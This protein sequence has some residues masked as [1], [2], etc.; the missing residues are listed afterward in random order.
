MVVAGIAFSK[1]ESSAYIT[2]KGSKT[3]IVGRVLMYHSEWSGVGA[4]SAVFIMWIGKRRCIKFVI[5]YSL[6]INN[7]S[8][9]DLRGFT[10]SDYFWSTYP[11]GTKEMSVGKTVQDFYQ[12]CRGVCSF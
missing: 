9:V 1:K 2:C 10:Q 11:Y 7:S 3:N 12:S 5:L 8:I 4:L 6:L